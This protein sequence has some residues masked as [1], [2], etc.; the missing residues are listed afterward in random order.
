MVKQKDVPEFH[1][2]AN[3]WVGSAGSWKSSGSCSTLGRRVTNRTGGPGPAPSG[4][5][6]AM[7]PQPSAEDTFSW[8][9]HM[10]FA[11]RNH[12]EPGL[13]AALINKRGAYQLVTSTESQ[14]GLEKCPVGRPLSTVLTKNS[15]NQTDSTM[16]GTQEMT[17]KYT[18]GGADKSPLT[19]D[20]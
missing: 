1:G 13:W 16:L 12:E 9:L 15:L 5:G 19:G 2:K 10:A 17:H 18:G 8:P 20:K 7:G 6:R 14:A 4:A 11:K 3:T